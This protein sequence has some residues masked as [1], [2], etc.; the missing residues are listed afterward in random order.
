MENVV[1]KKGIKQ[2]IRENIGYAYAII[3]FMLTIFGEKP[4][5]SYLPSY[6]ESYY[7]VIIIGFLLNL[8]VITSMFD[9]PFLERIDFDIKSFKALLVMNLF[10]IF[11][12]AFVL[13]LI[14]MLEYFGAVFPDTIVNSFGIIFIVGGLFC[15]IAGGFHLVQKLIEKP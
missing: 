1:E 7:V 15:L 9:I 10:F 13:G 3:W 14:R 4:I 12:L 2:W 5:S 8:A 6:L 11:I